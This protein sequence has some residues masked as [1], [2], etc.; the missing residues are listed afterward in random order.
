[1]SKLHLA[2]ALL[3][4]RQ[5]D[6]ARARDARRAMDEKQA[7]ASLLDETDDLPCHSDGECG[8]PLR[9]HI[10]EEEDKQIRMP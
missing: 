5:A 9:L 6:R 1:M 3:G 8:R 2:A 4:D 7:L 10:I